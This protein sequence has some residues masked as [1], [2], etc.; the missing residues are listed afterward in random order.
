MVTHAIL[1]FQKNDGTAFT[2]GSLTTA[3]TISA[4]NLLYSLFS[5][6]Q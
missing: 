2:A 1:P 6:S 5:L 4:N 3:I